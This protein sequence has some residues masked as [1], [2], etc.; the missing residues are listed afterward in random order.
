MKTLDNLVEE[1]YN[2]TYSLFEEGMLPA[3]LQISPHRGDV[4]GKGENI[5]C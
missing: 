2:I 1:E 3:P 5:K 4:I